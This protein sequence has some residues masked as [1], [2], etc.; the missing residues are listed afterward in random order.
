MSLLVVVAMSMIVV[1]VAVIMVVTV[2]FTM[3]VVMVMV[4]LM[5][6]ILKKNAKYSCMGVLLLKNRLPLMVLLLVDLMKLSL[7]NFGTKWKS[8]VRMHLINR[9]QRL[10]LTY[11]IKQHTLNVTMNLN[12]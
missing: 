11:L 5:M 8:S 10:M 9:M 1:A 3:L 4:V 7:I 2:T 12:S 6:K